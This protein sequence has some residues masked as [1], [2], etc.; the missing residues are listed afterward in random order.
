[1]D[2]PHLGHLG[3]GSSSPGSSPSPSVC[4][5]FFSL[6]VVQ[7]SSVQFKRVSMCSEKPICV[8]PPLLSNVAVDDG[9][10]SSFPGRSSS[11]A[12]RFRSSWILTS[13]QQTPPW[14][15]SGRAA[16]RLDRSWIV[17]A[18][19]IAFSF[20]CPPLVSLQV[21]SSTAVGF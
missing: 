14:V 6:Q 11:T 13:S 7:F 20:C 1:M 19:V 8:P 15:A 18:W 12:G 4:P 16:G 21:G 17:L 2:R 10:L 3:L 9:T 5:P